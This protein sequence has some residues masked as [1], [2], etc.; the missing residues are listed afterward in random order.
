MFGDR[1]GWFVNGA[2]K[3]KSE[4]DSKAFSMNI[5]LMQPVFQTI[6]SK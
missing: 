6:F 4:T 2:L 3:E 5:R 1:K